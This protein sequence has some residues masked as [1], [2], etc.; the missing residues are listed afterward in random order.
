MK[1]LHHPTAPPLGLTLPPLTL[2]AAT[3]L[4]SSLHSQLL[5][6]WNIRLCPRLLPSHAGLNSNTRFP[7]LYKEL[8]LPRQMLDIAFFLYCQFFP[9]THETRSTVQAEFIHHAVSTPAKLGAHTR[10]LKEVTQR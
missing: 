5:S 2:L 10:L 9:L 7:D 4:S 1:T 6:F 3:F 8:C